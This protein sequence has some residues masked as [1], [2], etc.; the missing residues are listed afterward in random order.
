MTYDIEI[1]E[2]QEKSRRIID[3]LNQLNEGRFNGLW[4][5]QPHQYHP[6]KTYFEMGLW[7]IEMWVSK[8][9]LSIAGDVAVE[10]TV[11]GEP[12][13]ISYTSFLYNH[14]CPTITVSYKRSAADIAADIDNRLY[15]EM[16]ELAQAGKKA[17]G[18][19]VE[20]AEDV[21]RAFDVATKD[22]DMVGLTG[23]RRQGQ[24]WARLDELY[25]PETAGFGQ[26]GGYNEHHRAKGSLSG[27]HD[28]RFNECTFR[29][30]LPE[31]ANSLIRH[32]AQL[33]EHRIPE[34]PKIE[35]R[36]VQPGAVYEVWAILPN[37]ERNPTELLATF[38]E[39]YRGDDTLQR[40]VYWKVRM[41]AFEFIES[42]GIDDDDII[43]TKQDRLGN[44][45]VENPN[46][47]TPLV[48]SVLKG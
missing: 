25:M 12:T 24:M 15:P 48:P 11:K 41:A 30:V 34:P 21:R 47:Y 35:L 32:L 31:E 23:D 29:D 28:G 7:A 45:T 33:R 27:Y 44:T 22:I 42:L 13:K 20:R 3:A 26:R 18:E 19:L 43:K 37:D 5:E 39:E 14:G 4:I 46:R 2:L 6:R 10:S 8:S 40:N 17:Y 1:E 16:L 9:R 38:G 36:A